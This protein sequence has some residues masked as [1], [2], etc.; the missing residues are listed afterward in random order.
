MV[1]SGEP[2]VW[3]PR[4]GWL[5]SVCPCPAPSPPGLNTRPSGWKGLVPGR[6]GPAWPCRLV[7]PLLRQGSVPPSSS[8]PGWHFSGSQGRPGLLEG[9]AGAPGQPLCVGLAGRRVWPP[10]PPTPP[11][12]PPRG[13]AGVYRKCRTRLGGGWRGP[14]RCV[15]ARLVGLR[16]GAPLPTP[17]TRLFVVAEGKGPTSRAALPLPRLFPPGRHTLPASQTPRQ[18][19]PPPQGGF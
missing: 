2:G 4:A 11:G 18:P 16:A 14:G 9:P 13:S 1:S 7:V 8:R 12:P 5:Q 19:T 3:K 17:R 6:G 10:H 15:L